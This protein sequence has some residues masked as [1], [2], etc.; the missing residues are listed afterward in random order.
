MAD[1]I[2]FEGHGLTVVTF[3]GRP[4]LIAR[5]VC[6]VLGYANEGGRGVDKITGD[7]ADEFIEGQDFERLE[8]EDLSLFATTESVGAK[9]RHLILLYESGVD[10]VCLLTRKN[11]GKRLR[12]TLVDNVTWRM[13]R[14][15]LSDDGRPPVRQIESPA[16]LREMR[17]MKREERLEREQ[18]A[19]A[20]LRL[21]QMRPDLSQPVKDMLI[22]KATE[23]ETGEPNPVGVLP[24][25]EAGWMAPTQIARDLGVTPNRIGR[26]ITALDLRRNIPDLARAVLN[27][28]AGIDRSVT[29]YEYSPSAVEQIRDHL[30][31]TGHIVPLRA[32]PPPETEGE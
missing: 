8:G 6:A 10:L 3:K 5:E 2:N 28:A 26:A 32:L 25:V 29:T 17:L 11:V 27:K 20:Y 1:I 9:V 30:I 7:W 31:A 21:V 13:R 16:M 18:K 4:A 14:G 23:A 22:A 15:L 24:V 19:G 12:R